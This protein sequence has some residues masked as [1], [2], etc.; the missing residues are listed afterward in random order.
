MCDTSTMQARIRR[1][2]GSRGQTGSINMA[3]TR[4]SD[5]ATRTLNLSKSRPKYTTTSGFAN[6][7]QVWPR[8]LL[9][10]VFRIT[11]NFT[12]FRV[13]PGYRLLHP[14]FLLKA[15]LAVHVRYGDNT[16]QN[17][18]KKSLPVALEAKPEVEIWRKPVFPTKRPDFI[19]L[20]IL[21]GVYLAPL[22]LQRERI[23]TLAHCNGRGT[24]SIFAFRTTK[25]E[26]SRFF[27]TSTN[28]VSPPQC[29][30]KLCPCCN[31]ASSPW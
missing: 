18:A 15:F 31:A 2:K 1:K 11:V 22:R 6:L 29:D 9:T 13:L 20:R 21:Y 16:G 10:H 24:L 7:L 26:F 8:R 23:L 27:Q 19:R 25:S 30:T 28:F 14:V 4:F 17:K 3:A 5:S 12:T